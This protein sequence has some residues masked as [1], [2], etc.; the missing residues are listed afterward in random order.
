MSRILNLLK[1]A[2]A[3]I[4]LSSPLGRWATALSNEADQSAAVSSQDVWNCA[5][6]VQ[7]N[8]VVHVSG[9]GADTVNQALDS[10]DASSQMP[11]IGFVTSKPTPTT[12]VVQ[13]SG[14]LPNTFS[15]LV[16]GTL[17]YVSGT[18]AGKIVPSGTI[19]PVGSL[20][21]QVGVARSTTELVAQVATV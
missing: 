8:D 17:Y 5:A 16:P 7:V 13:Y 19:M 18:Q 12:C 1:A 11:A 20:V 3:Q 14:K 6:S 10:G 2:S 4:Q 15:G 9:S 21:Q